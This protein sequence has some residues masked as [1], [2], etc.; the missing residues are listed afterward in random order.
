MSEGSKLLFEVKEEYINNYP[1]QFAYFVGGDSK[2]NVDV[3][4]KDTNLSHISFTTKEFNGIFKLADKQELRT[5]FKE[6][7]GYT[8]EQIDELER[9]LD[10]NKEA[11]E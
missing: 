9:E 3:R 2:G 4:F 7:H 5:I 11:I 6:L 10:S 1:N 8:D